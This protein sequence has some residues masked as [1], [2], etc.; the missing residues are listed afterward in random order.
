[1]PDLIIQLIIIMLVCG[2]VYWVWL[3][4]APLMPDRRA[5][6]QLRQRV[7][8]HPDRGNRAVL[9]DHST[10]TPARAHKPALT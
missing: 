3:K 4:L 7:G 2:F 8:H 10:T 1:M 5:F 6:C 9:C